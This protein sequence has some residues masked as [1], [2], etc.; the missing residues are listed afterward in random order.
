MGIQLNAVATILSAANDF[1]T[2]VDTVPFEDEQAADFREAT[3]ASNRCALSP[4]N[5]QCNG[6]S[7][8]LL[9]GWRV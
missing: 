7:H 2:I 5:G 9:G 1:R 4:F 8:L 6:P 3:G